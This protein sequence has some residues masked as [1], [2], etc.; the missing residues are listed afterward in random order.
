MV[1]RVCKVMEAELESEW[2]F[3][4]SNWLYNQVAYTILCK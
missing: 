4:E 1:A 3:Q 2:L